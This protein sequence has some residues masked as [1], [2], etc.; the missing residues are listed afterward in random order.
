MS[1]SVSTTLWVASIRQ[2]ARCHMGEHIGAIQGILSVRLH[3][4]MGQVKEVSDSQRDLGKRHG[5]HVG[6]SSN[7]GIIS[8]KIRSTLPWACFSI[9]S[10]FREQMW[11]P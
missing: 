10:H 6:P 1:I 2:N 4:S 8:G 7:P 5:L 3:E 11:L 9:S